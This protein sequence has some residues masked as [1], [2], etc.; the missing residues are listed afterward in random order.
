M[1]QVIGLCVEGTKILD[2]CIK[3]DELI[4][5]G[6]GAVYN[7]SVKGVKVTKGMCLMPSYTIEQLLYDNVGLAFPTCISVNNAVAHFSPLA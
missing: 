4:E 2:I 1:K 7:K 5:A 6:T 3:G